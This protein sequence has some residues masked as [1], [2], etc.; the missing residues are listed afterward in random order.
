MLSVSRRD[1][2]AAIGE[3]VDAIARQIAPQLVLGELAR[4]VCAAVQSA[5]GAE[6]AS[7]LLVEEGGL[8]FAAVTGPAADRLL[9]RLIGAGEGVAGA[10]A[11]TRRAVIVRDGERVPDWIREAST[12]AGFSP[13]TLVAAPLVVD[14]RVVGVVEAVN[15]AGTTEPFHERHLEF[16]ERLA[17]H[18]SAAISNAIL[19]EELRRSRDELARQNELLEQRVEERTRLLAKAKDEWELSFDSI[20]DPLA[21]VEDGVVRRSNLAFAAVMGRDIRSVP[22]MRC[23]EAL[24][25]RTAPCPG[26]PVDDPGRELP[27]ELELEIGGT[28]YLRRAF[29]F[30]DPGRPGAWVVS[31]RD[32]TAERRLAAQIRE[33]EYHQAVGRLAAGAAHEINNP[34]AFLTAAIRTMR[35]YVGVIRD[36]AARTREATRAATEGRQ[37][38]ALRQL[39]QLAQEAERSDLDHILADASAVLAEGE[40]GARRVTAIVAALQSLGSTANERSERVDLAEVVDRALERLRSSPRFESEIVW[41]HR[42]RAPAVVYPAQLEGAIYELLRNAAQASGKG[43]VEVSLRTEGDR[44]AIEIGDEGPGIADAIRPYLFDPFFTT[45]SVG[46]GAGLG[47]TIAWGAARRHAGTIELEAREP[48]GTIARLSV[49]AAGAADPLVSAGPERP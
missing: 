18:V 9:G 46:D 40:E 43:R 15:R 8:R 47:L 36:F 35:E 27:L 22:G 38:E 34:M 4:S 48:R 29:R 41:L 24:F 12:E 19:A 44:I 28:T 17:P 13:R 45:R 11:S 39:R 16:L 7:V 21:I 20:A 49:S 42:D 2:G 1:E 26:C 31:Y 25:G 14:D 33:S 23:Y 6:A 5:L 37:E 10:V 32:I 30:D 3:A